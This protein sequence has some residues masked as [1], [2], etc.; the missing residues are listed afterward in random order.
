MRAKI[1]PRLLPSL[2][3]EGFLGNFSFLGS[4]RS[5]EID[6]QAEIFFDMLKNKDTECLKS[7]KEKDN[8]MTDDKG[9]VKRR[10][11]KKEEFERRRT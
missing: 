1:L 7:E 6:Y 8:L 11:L 4:N 5:D 3:D 10:V 2:L 9:L